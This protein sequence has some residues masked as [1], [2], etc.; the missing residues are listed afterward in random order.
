MRPLYLL[1][2]NIISEPD[3]ISPNPDVMKK[4]EET[5]SYSAITSITLSELLYG[6]RRMSNGKKKD[7]LGKYIFDVVQPEY[8]TIGF[9]NHAAVVFA[10]LRADLE[11]EGKTK[12]LLDLQIA[13]IAI[14]NNM[15]LV[16][17]NTKDFENIPGLMV[18]NW[19][20]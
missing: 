5:V 4:I 19:F 20:V 17:R 15:I 9:D 8:G 7:K 2:T 14:A 6:W 16:T 13:S 10:D 11:F 1:D 18:E 3:K 12:P